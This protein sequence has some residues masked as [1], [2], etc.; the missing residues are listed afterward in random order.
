[1]KHYLSTIWIVGA[2]FLAPL[3]S[4]AQTSGN[5][6]QID[7]ILMD[8]QGE[9]L[10]GATVLLK[11]N[12][13]KGVITDVDGRFSLGNIPVNSIVIFRYTGYDDLERTFPKSESKLRI[14]LQVKTT[15]MNDV[16]VTGR[17]TARKVSVTGSITT[18][19]VQDLQ[20]PNVSLTNMLAGR[21][22]GIIAVQRS[23]EPGRGSNSE[24]WVNGISTF[25]ANASALVL[26][27]GVEGNLNDIDPA[28]IESF[29]VLK[30]ASA[31]AVYGVRGANGVVVVTTKRGKAGELKIN[32]KANVSMSE[33]T[34]TQ[35][36]VDAADYAR[37]ANEASFNRGLT[38]I[39]TPTQIRLFEVG[40]DPDLYPNVNWGDEI[41][42]DRTYNTQQF[43]S[44]YGG[45]ENARYYFSVGHTN[46][47]G[48]FKQDKS[49]INKYDS[50]LDW[51]RY[52]FRTNVDANL[53]KT[54]LLGLNLETTM[55]TDYGPNINRNDLWNQQA[56]LPPGL[57]PVKFSTGELSGIGIYADQ[58]TPYVLLNH[59][60][61]KKVKDV[62]S[63]ITVSL[64]Q[65]LDM[66]TEGLAFTALYSMTHYN[67]VEE[68]R[69]KR[70]ELYRSNG[71]NND[72]T[73]RL[74][75]TAELVQPYPGKESASWRSDY[76]EASLQYNRAFGDHRI[77][78]L[79]HIYRQEDTNS[80]NNGQ[81]DAIIPVR[82]QTIS[83]RV[84]Y[85]FKDTY[86]AEFNIGYSG[87][88]NFKPS[89]QYGWFPAPSIGWV[90]TNY[91]FVKE[92]IP[93]LS[94]L[95]LRASYGIVGNSKVLYSRFPYLSIIQGGGS[96]WG[97]S[98]TESRASSDNITWEKTKKTNL[99]IDARLLNE[100]I[101]L[102]ADFFRSEVDGIL[103]YRE[104]IPNEVGSGIPMG[105]VGSMKSWGMSGN[106]AWNQVINKDMSF[107]LRS[108]LT[109][110]R[111]EVTHYEQ[112]GKNY[113]YQTYT[114]YPW[115][116]IRGLMSLGLFKNEA[117]IQSSP[118]QELGSEVRPGDIKYQDING[119]GVV[120][121]E[122][123]VP[124]SY[125]NVP[126]IQYGFA[127]AYT[128]KNLT[129]SVFFN[130]VSRV[131]FFYGGTGYYPFSAGDRGNVLT[132]VNNQ[133][134]R[135][136]PAE[137]S[138]NPATENPDARFPR[139]TYGNNGNNNRPSTF[140]LADG[141]YLR[142]KNV[143][144]NYSLPS[145]WLRPLH[146]SAA[147]ISLIGDNLAVWDKVKL[148]DPETASGNGTAYPLQR[149]YTIQLNLTF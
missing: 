29:S 85:G 108:N 80:D 139:L 18:V 137:Y 12:P 42:A 96:I 56:M 22:A 47:T 63:K 66:L 30:D 87:S 31:T 72:G 118:K 94:F 121:S 97:E 40:L 48:I 78:G 60:G 122:D 99:G 17:G 67:I 84:T 133:Q 28:D 51:H 132:I 106:I 109:F 147:T 107:T 6:I 135:W 8:E 16:V 117:D 46:Q 119:D 33:S 10:I 123:E 146:V 69:V 90:P 68:T 44:V 2:L 26:I 25:G 43:L 76:M 54:T 35:K 19:D 103:Q 50:N 113:P 112:A 65:K 23:G 93:F 104:Y 142:L 130:G 75:R 77:G 45:G 100:S 59:S 11:D 91:D 74:A 124:L 83:G 64:N 82:Y 126:Q 140:W 120:N 145:K 3:F 136:T 32:F 101:E 41:L 15:L 86:L 36:Y 5:G 61:Y 62:K 143:E 81:Y 92:N 53:T 89:H 111:N 58:M 71:R 134:N 98:W 52:N 7:G 4:Q 24:F 131:N 39:Y 144:V 57:V 20:V 114:G 95:K 125:A 9:P 141:K 14:S 37:L 129:V 13:A 34:R 79:L 49:G 27:D 55:T 70:P 127:A 105:N 102:T 138:G 88:E 110:S 148:W 116:V 149:A 38:P 128:W 1:M 21:V 115:G 73:L